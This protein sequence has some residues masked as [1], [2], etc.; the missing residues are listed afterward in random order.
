MDLALAAMAG[1]AV[2][3]VPGAIATRIL[4]SG[5]SDGVIRFAQ[6]IALGLSFWPILFLFT[7]LLDWS[8]DGNSARVFFAVLVVALIAIVVKRRANLRA[9]D[10]MERAAIVLIAIVTFTR[11]KQIENMVLPLWVDSV[12]HSMIVRLLV[13]HGRLPDSYAP[14]IP[15]ST[16]YYH[17]G[18]HAAAA[19]VAW[20]SGLTASSEV[21]RMVLAFGQLLNVLT[22]TAVYCAAAV[23]LRN[24][25]TALLAGTL[26]TL[27]SIF[28]A[29][30]VSWGRYTQLA[31]L[32]I[33]PALAS[34]FWK[35]GRHPR[36][37]R[38]SE[39][40][41]LAAGLVLVHARVTVVFAVLAVIL[42]AI[43]I[44]QRRWKGLAW[45]GAAGI[46]ALL[47]ASPWIVTVLHAPQVRM[48]VAPA[49]EERPRWET[50][51]ATPDDLVWVPHNTFLFG[52]ASGGLLGFA[53][54]RLSLPTR[55]AAIG[56]WLLLVVLLQRRATRKRRTRRAAWRIGIVVLWILLTALLVNLDRF[57]LPRMRVVTN[58][59]TVIMLFLPLSIV[60]AH[61]L[62]FAADAIADEVAPMS[63][64]RAIT[65]AA[66]LL[67]GVTGASRILHIV[68]P[69]TVLATAADLRALE[70]I[71]AATP[72]GARFAVGVQPWIGGSYIGI[73]GG[74]WIPLVAER[75]S[76]LPPGLYPWVM[77]HD[78]VASITRF[79]ATWYQSAQTADAAMLGALR[80]HGVT[81]VYFGE[82]NTTPLRGVAAA[83]PLLARIYSTDGVEIY[84]LR[85]PY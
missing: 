76:I 29:Y 28:P 45:C 12:H 32:L 83:S 15:E 20:I 78:R 25:R 48:I 16:F 23:P 35:L 1:I 64:R 6:E 68:N 74:Y 55:L 22:F 33:L 46:A 49:V 42:S 73:D 54:F 39:V 18:F 75:E 50:S 30:Y 40:A 65:L 80:E 17:W 44:M 43:L 72:P 8:W 52:L 56:W 13:D 21:P 82:R 11:V 5:S 69:A 62:R 79:L 38:A 70:W 77:P 53:P 84:A 7:T 4:N 9:P 37:R 63:R 27:V 24:R 58:S 31:G 10:L 14:F 3:W 61:L 66:T 41:L 47:I 67:I 51:N 85:G 81:H 57:G 2:L 34:S 36:M 19:F 26:A 59:A 60:G 71:R